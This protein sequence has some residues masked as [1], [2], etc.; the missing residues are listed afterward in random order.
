MLLTFVKITFYLR[1]FIKSIFD[2]ARK[3]MYSNKRKKKAF[4]YMCVYVIVNGG[5]FFG[6]I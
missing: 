5:T 4:L 6:C 1:K 2:K 3:E